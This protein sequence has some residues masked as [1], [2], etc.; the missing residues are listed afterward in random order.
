MTVNDPCQQYVVDAAAAVTSASQP[1]LSLLDRNGNPLSLLDFGTG[2]IGVPST[3]QTIIVRNN[4]AATIR[5][6][7][8]L[9]AGAHLNDFTASTTCANL[10]NASGYPFDLGSGLECEIDVTFTAKGNNV[11]TADVVI[12]ANVDLPVALTG[13]ASTTSSGGGDS[14]G[15]AGGGCTIT[16]TRSLDPTLLL[17]VLIST[18]IV[19][20]RGARK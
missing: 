14:S 10:S 12:A 6:E 2:L 17:L 9:V 4:S 11:R 20:R 3:P 18:V 13:A 19:V 8:V 15:S 1:I 5:I 7:N 16:T